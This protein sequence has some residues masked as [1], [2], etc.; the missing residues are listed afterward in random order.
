MAQR[1]VV[2]RAALLTRLKSYPLD[3]YLHLH[4]HFETIEWDKLSD[5]VSLPMGFILDGVLVFCRLAISTV[6]AKQDDR[7][8]VFLDSS[9]LRNSPIAGDVLQG[10]RA[11]RGFR[12]WAVGV[13]SVI[14]IV[15]VLLSFVNAYY[16]FSR[17]RTYT[18]FGRDPQ[19]KK[20]AGISSAKKSQ[21]D[22]NTDGRTPSSF[23]PWRTII[24][25]ITHSESPPAGPDKEIWEL[26]M[27]NPQLFNLR[28]FISYSPLHTLVL[29]YT[30]YSTLIRNI[31]ICLLLTGQL[32]LLTKSFLQQVADKSLIFGEMFEEYEKKVVR[33][34]MSVVRHDAAV[35]ADG[36][37][38]YYSPTLERHF[39]TRDIR[40]RSSSSFFESAANSPFGSSSPYRH[41]AMNSRPRQ[42]ALPGEGPLYGTYNGSPVRFRAAGHSSDVSRNSTPLDSARAATGYAHSP[43]LRPSPAQS[44]RLK[45][46]S[47]KQMDNLR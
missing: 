26:Q 14:S 35:G 25:R 37:V 29:F 39:V 32:Y 4:E 1:R 17:R 45:G 24:D 43:L 20:L 46:D 33:P 6:A 36:S 7:S 28:L 2:R 5:T 3:L 30:S 31:T 42:S 44:R 15:S 16:I 11:T 47:G 9:R 27:W 23:S 40:P 12:G 21:L 34:K 13:L 18:F 22:M 19:D 10:R 41:S 8:E 38:E